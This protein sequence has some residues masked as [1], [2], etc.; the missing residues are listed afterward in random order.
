MAGI[1][2]L[3]GAIH[4]VRARVI[5][6][7]II[8]FALLLCSL[9]AQTA[10]LRFYRRLEGTINGKYPIIMHLERRA[11]KVSGW[12]YYAS[13]REVLSLTGDIAPDGRATLA[14]HPRNLERSEAKITTGSFTGT[15][16]PR[17]FSGLWRGE[18]GKTQLPFSVID[19]SDDQSVRLT[20]YL[21]QKKLPLIQGDADSP[22]LSASLELL[23]PESV[24]DRARRAALRSF[25][26]PGAPDDPDQALAAEW[27]S[28]ADDYLG[29]LD[30][31]YSPD[32]KTMYEWEY[33]G[34]KSVIMNDAGFLCIDR[35]FY[36]YTGGA[37][38]NYLDAFS[39]LDLSTGRKIA[40]A[41][42]FLPAAGKPLRLLIEARIRD[43][44]EIKPDATLREA[45]LFVDR[46]DP[47]ENF[48]LAVDGIG[49]HYDIYQILPY[50]AG[51]MDVFLPWDA[52]KD[53]VKPDS[54]VR[55]LFKR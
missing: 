52:I 24:A 27:Q 29:C 16:G 5:V 9:E 12:Y 22:A 42:V 50:A 25:L 31:N 4:M 8:F 53:L 7:F 15:I 6:T 23:Y 39:I 45:G 21:L 55:R 49:F 14:E 13:R 43:R 19:R 20:T 3:E 18:D 1:T 32:V 10:G 36:G 48:Y 33:E 34:K 46:V 35:F 51:A 40:L 11:E 41:D 26:A 54:P 47:V 38:G 44:L 28:L 17:G 37:H 2:S 30:D